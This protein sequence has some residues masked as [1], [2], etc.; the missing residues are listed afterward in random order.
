MRP[1]DGGCR[2]HHFRPRPGTPTNQP[3][4][5]PTKK[6]NSARADGAVFDD[7]KA[8]KKPIVFVYGAR[9]LTGGL[10]KGE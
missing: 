10:C 6:T 2:R 3:K 8:R 5:H 7:T 1:L 4:P 9:P